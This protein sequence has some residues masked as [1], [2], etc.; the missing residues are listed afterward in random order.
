VDAGRSQATDRVLALDVGGTLLKGALVGRDGTVALRRRRPTGRGA[1]PD[2][3]VASILDF[4]AE[5]SDLCRRELGHPPLGVAVVVPGVVDERAGRAVFAANLGWRDVPL[6]GLLED[7]LQL[8]GAL[9][10]D[11]RAG[12]LAEGL[13][14][15]ARGARDYLFIPIGTGI[16][17]AAV[18]HGL[19]Y[20]G[21]HAL[22]M[23][24]GHVVIDPEGPPCGCGARG[25][26]EMFASARAVSD[27][28]REASGEAVEAQVVVE[29][30]GQGDAVAAATW[31]TAVE[32]LATG[33]AICTTLFDPALVVLGGGLANSGQLLSPLRRALAER[34]TFQ[35]VPQLTGAALGDE[36]GCMGAAL[37]AWLRL[38][39]HEDALGWGGAG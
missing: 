26:I 19:R 24:I 2:A 34:L 37:L 14:G 28:Y 21:A 11:V 20:E 12:A 25:C 30:A 6:R 7:R 35:H 16:G 27:R 9:G 13:I 17:G 23:E 5:L 4:A 29:R 10:H 3:V 38:G 36:A 15:A 22:A 39:V 8:P 1:G 32:A 31:R 33:L 18:L